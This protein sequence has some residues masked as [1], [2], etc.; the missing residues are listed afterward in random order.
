MAISSGPSP[1]PPSPL[2]VA[3]TVLVIGALSPV[4][5]YVVRHLAICGYAV[6]SLAS[7]RSD[8]AQLR[9]LGCTSVLP[10]RPSD[11]TALLR[12]ST[13]AHFAVVIPF[14]S[15]SWI[16]SDTVSSISSTDYIL[17]DESPP[18]PDNGNIAFVTTRVLVAARATGIRHIV[19]LSTAA[20]MAAGNN[21]YNAT[22]ATVVASVHTQNAMAFA[23]REILSAGTTYGCN[24]TVLRV[25]LLWGADVSLLFSD[26]AL[27]AGGAFDVRT[28]HVANV[29]VAITATLKARVEGAFF[30]GDDGRMSLCQF[31]AKHM[32]ATGATKQVVA[33]MGSG[34]TGMSLRMTRALAWIARG[35]AWMIGV[36][37][38]ASD[39][40][41]CAMG[42][43]L[44]FDDEDT[45]QKIGYMPVVSFEEGMREIEEMNTGCAHI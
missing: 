13:N 15:S 23:E 35:L 33:R 19:L 40:R 3:P 2:S 18:H 30:V 20:L 45:R 27:I 1:Q 31:V 44:W 12:A 24:G 25:G 7:S 38:I 9:T 17:C 5:R 4:G 14:P 36:E 28:T 41:I 26:S 32:A 10:G 11:S 39:A 6:H 34:K 16:P 42:A 8:R 21:V 22:D 29:A 43:E 37:G